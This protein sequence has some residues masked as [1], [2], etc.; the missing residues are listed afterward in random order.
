MYFLVGTP[1]LPPSPT[2]DTP[3]PPTPLQSGELYVITLGNR[4]EKFVQS[5]FQKL[6]F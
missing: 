4:L 6:N 2:H 3:P 5:C 1:L